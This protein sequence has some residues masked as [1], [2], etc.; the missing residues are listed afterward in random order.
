MNEA[1]AEGLFGDIQ[2]RGGGEGHALGG[3]DT[4]WEGDMFISNDTSKEF[5]IISII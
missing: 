4:L 1:C 5:A 3:E 2:G